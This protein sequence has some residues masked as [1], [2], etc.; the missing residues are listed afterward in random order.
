MSAT[1]VSNIREE[2]E[3]GWHRKEGPAQLQILTG[4]KLCRHL[5]GWPTS[6]SGKHHRGSVPGA[7][8]LLLR[9]RSFP[10]SSCGK[11]IVKKKKK[12][13]KKEEKVVGLTR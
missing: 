3:I 8:R 7:Q 4:E 5:L 2:E 10:S 12:R 9:E 11:R 1:E 6:G 13:K